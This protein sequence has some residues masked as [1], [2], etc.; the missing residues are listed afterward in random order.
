M[1]AALR[2]SS[3]TAAALLLAAATQ[4]GAQAAPRTLTLGAPEVEHAEPFSLLAGVRELRDGRVVVADASEKRV[5]LLD[6][7][8]GTATAIGREGSGPGE[9]R[10]PAGVFPYVGDS[11]LLHDPGNARFLTLDP[12]GRP[13]RAWQFTGDPAEMVRLLGG[14][15]GVDAEG[16]VYYDDRG[17]GPAPVG[18]IPTARDTAVVYR[19]D[20]RAQRRDSVG[21]VRL[22]VVA[23]TSETDGG[24][25]ADGQPTQIRTTGAVRIPFSARDDWTV[26]VDGRLAFV[27]AADYHVEW[28]APN[29]RRVAGTPVAYTPVPVTERDK[30]EWRERAGRGGL[31]VA[32]RPGVTPPPQRKPPEPARWPREKPAFETTTLPFAAGALVAPD[33]RL[34]VPRHGPAADPV[35]RYDVFDGFGAVVAQVALP[36]RTRVVGFGARSVYL[37]RTDDDDLQYLQRHALPR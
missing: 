20:P 35:R 11:T 2:R 27:R 32:A 29:G 7:A 30:A 16:R 24:P 4:A 34:W 1:R 18:G 5:E 31:F 9:W 37:V 22:N 26:G 12:A 17:F 13:A 8:R 15:H 23:A 6:L 14:I 36:P 3:T 28:V 10:M 25:D 21:W 33:G 19:Y